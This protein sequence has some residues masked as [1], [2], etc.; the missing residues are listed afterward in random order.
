MS[1]YGLPKEFMA[2][3]ETKWVA[4]K[5][6]FCEV[7]PADELSKEEMEQL[8]Q[9]LEGNKI[10][11]K[12]AEIFAKQWIEYKKQ[13]AKE[14]SESSFNLT[15]E[16]MKQLQQFVDENKLSKEAFTLIRNAWVGYKK[17]FNETNPA[18][19]L[20]KEE[21]EQ[22]R[23]F[24]EEKLGMKEWE[25]LAKQWVEYK[26]QLAEANKPK[27]KY[28]T[29]AEKEEFKMMFSKFGVP[30]S[31]LDILVQKLNEYKINFSEKEPGKE[32]SKEDIAALEEF[33]NTLN[34]D[35]ET[36]VMLNEDL[37]RRWVE[38]KFKLAEGLKKGELTK[39][40]EEYLNR[41]MDQG[42]SKEALEEIRAKLVMYKRFFEETIPVKEL[43]DTEKAELKAFMA[44]YG[45]PDDEK[46]FNLMCEQ[47]VEYKNMLIKS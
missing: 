40:D 2:E 32:L 45:I 41:L 43:T 18:D 16:E 8:T 35:K 5:T 7:E 15:E 4:Y 23:I 24:C 28:V 36:Y 44:A 19:E 13:L 31:L 47:W 30:E 27:D 9:F 46:M 42:V 37:Q 38:L 29:E 14:L 21:M 20:S 12:E 3:I 6:A 22:L 1:N 39:Q 17:S 25:P 33:L 26:K 11:A 10:S 34:L